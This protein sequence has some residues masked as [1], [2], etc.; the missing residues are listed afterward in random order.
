VQTGVKSLGWENRMAHPLPIQSWK[1][2]GPCV[3]SAVKFGASALILSDMITS[4]VFAWLI[5]DIAS[6]SYSPNLA[7]FGAGTT[8]WRRAVVPGA[9][10]DQ[11]RR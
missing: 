6:P 3:V 10:G 9:E 1:V 11:A 4:G 8:F 5:G 7:D 2:I